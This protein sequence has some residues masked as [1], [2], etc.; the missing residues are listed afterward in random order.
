M[1]IENNKNVY[2]VLKNLEKTIFINSSSKIVDELENIHEKHRP[3]IILQ[4]QTV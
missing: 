1:N 2:E 4:N 3:E